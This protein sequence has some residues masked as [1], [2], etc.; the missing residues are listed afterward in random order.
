MTT[1]T[2]TNGENTQV[3]DTGA[4]AADATKD[5][6]AGTILGGADDAAGKTAEGAEAGAKGAETGTE[7]EKKA[8][9][10]DGEK[11]PDDEKKADDDKPAGPPE[12]Y[13]LTM[14]EG[15]ELDAALLEKV[16][17]VFRDIGLT[18]E[19]ANKLANVFAE[20]RVSEAQGQS[21][22]YAQQVED[23]GKAARDDK[24][25][26]GAAFDASVAQAQK[27]IG[28]FGSPELKTLLADGLGNHP[29]LIRFCVRVGKAIGEDGGVEASRAA[30]PRSAAETLYDH[31]TSQK[32]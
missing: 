10:A 32:R 6:P 2:T 12:K 8:D 3:A 5:T 29:E 17:P 21:D 26:G 1:E 18:N 28:Q 20:Y 13:E 27:A 9:A 14:P 31:P 7:G 16:D 11:K 15:V 30:T 4:T 24:E 25:F 22:A 19:Q 23:W